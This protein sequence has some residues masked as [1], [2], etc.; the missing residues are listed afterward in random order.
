MGLD[1]GLSGADTRSLDY[2]S[3]IQRRLAGN[4]GAV[5]DGPRFECHRVVIPH[6]KP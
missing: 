6:P 2:G 4:Q 1:L 5:L 3:G